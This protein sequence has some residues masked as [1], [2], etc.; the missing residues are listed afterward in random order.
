[1]SSKIN[2]SG[3]HLVLFL[4]SIANCWL[5]EPSATVQLSYVSQIRFIESRTQR[6]PFS[7]AKSKDIGCSHR[8]IG[9]FLLG[10]GRHRS[11]NAR[12]ELR[13]NGRVLSL[14]AVIS[15]STRDSSATKGGLDDLTP[16]GPAGVLL[17]EEVKSVDSVEVFIRLE[18]LGG[19]R[20]RISGGLLIDAPARAVWDVLTNYTA[21]SEYI[22]NIAESGARI[23]PDGRVHIEQ[24][25]ELSQY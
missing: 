4:S 7:I 19:N 24:V 8:S 16:R 6:Q 25:C 23:Q 9:S 20:R 5:I 13:N 11:R 15:P 12:T 2:Y 18:A 3:P 14:R 21:L 17:I 22:P 10:V 1:M